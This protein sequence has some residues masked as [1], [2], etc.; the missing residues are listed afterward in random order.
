MNLVDNFRD[1]LETF[2]GQYLCIARYKQNIDTLQ[3]IKMQENESLREFV[4]AL[5]KLYCKWNPTTWMLSSKFS[6]V[7]YVWVRYFLESLAKKPPTTIDDLFRLAKKYSMLEDDVRCSHT[8]DLSHRPIG[9]KR[10]GKEPQAFKSKKASRNEARAPLAPVIPRAIINYIHDGPL[11]EKYNSKR[12]RQRLLRAVTVRE[13]IS[14][15]RLDLASGN[16]HPID[17]V[18][19][20]PLVDLAQVLQQHRDTLILTLGIG[21][22]DVRRIPVDPG[23]S[24]DFLQVFV[25]KPNGIYALQL[26]EPGTD[27]VKVQWGLNNIP[28]GYRTTNPSRSNHPLMYN[29]QW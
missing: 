17:E 29:Y 12:K 21:D 23:S 4:K 6:S 9:Q 13:H 25:V 3:N 18:I 27:T 8:I 16:A 14:S 26:G 5:D 20:F 10:R 7:A 2:V 28:W 15:I 22:F 11:D 19:L 1:L 24:T